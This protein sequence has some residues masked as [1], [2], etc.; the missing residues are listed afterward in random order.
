MEGTKSDRKGGRE[1]TQ[2][3]YFN[4]FLNV[5][6]LNIIRKTCS[7][8]NLVTSSTTPTHTGQRI[9][10]TTTKATKTC[11]QRRNKSLLVQ[12]AQKPSFP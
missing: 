3:N 6:S 7:H 10:N 12:A 9:N 1:R 2:H 4:F 11:A 5:L 8:Q